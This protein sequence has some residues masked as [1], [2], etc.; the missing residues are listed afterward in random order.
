M[1]RYNYECDQLYTHFG[2]SAIK[3]SKK[4][5]FQIYF[6]GFTRKCSLHFNQKNADLKSKLMENIQKYFG[7]DFLIARTFEQVIFSHIQ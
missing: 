7:M 1:L 6:N 4:T 3:L 2:A 5:H